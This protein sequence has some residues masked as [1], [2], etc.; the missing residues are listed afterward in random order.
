MK[1][2]R[3]SKA[4][5]Q[6]LRRRLDQLVRCS[7]Y[8]AGICDNP[9]VFSDYAG[10]PTVLWGANWY[11]DKLPQICPHSVPHIAF[12]GCDDQEAGCPFFA[13]MAGPCVCRPIET[14]NPSFQGTPHGEEKA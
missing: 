9:K 8:N 1:S 6:A 5:P 7:D 2:E 12:K 3:K 10:F 11:A 4:N 13:P 14:P